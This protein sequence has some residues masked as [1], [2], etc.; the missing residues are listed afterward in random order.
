MRSFL[1]YIFLIITLL[2]SVLSLAQPKGLEFNLKK[3]KQFTERK[4]PSEK[5]ADKKFTKMRRFF[6]NTY[7]HFNYFFNANLKLNE[8]IEDSKRQF[9]DDY[10]QLL[11][12]FPYS[13]DETS[14]SSFLDSVLQKCTA[15]ILLHDLRNDWID[16]MYLVMGKAY[17]MRKN[18]DSAAMTFQYINYSFSPK[19]EGGYDKFIGSNAEEGSNALTIAT[20]EKKGTFSYLLS[21]PPSRNESFVWQVRTLTEDSNYIDASSLIETLRNDPQF[22]ERLKEELAESRAYLYY[23]MEMW[24]SATAYLVK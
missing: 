12:Y 6:Q 21:R 8:I 9:K 13:L 18:Y 17:L 22:P 23:K 24:D 1:R 4:L 3:P 19:E 15:G 2:P 11:P 5:L 16:N 10:T 20:K 14:R 7:T